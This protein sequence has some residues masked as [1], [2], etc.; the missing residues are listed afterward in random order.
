MSDGVTDALEEVDAL[1]G[2]TTL[3]IAP[4]WEGD[5]YLE[6]STLDE[7]VR[8]TGPFNLTGNPAVSVPF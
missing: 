5:N 8:T 3:M 1:A 2:L 4:A 7:A 6:D